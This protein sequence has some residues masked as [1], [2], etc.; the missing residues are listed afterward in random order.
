MTSQM[1]PLLLAARQGLQ[2]AA[3]GSI[4]GRCYKLLQQRWGSQTGACSS[5]TT[6]LYFPQYHHRLQQ[7]LRAASRLFAQGPSTSTST[8]TSSTSG[9]WR[10]YSPM[11]TPHWAR[12]SPPSS[13]LG[14]H[15]PSLPPRPLPTRYTTTRHPSLAHSTRTPSSTRAYSSAPRWQHALQEET[16]RC[17]G[18][19]FGA[20]LRSSGTGLEA[21][22]RQVALHCPDWLSRSSSTATITILNALNLV[23]GQLPKLIGIMLAEFVRCHPLLSGAKADAGFEYYVEVP[24]VGVEVWRWRGVEGLHLRCC[25]A[26]MLLV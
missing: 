12:T 19:S 21:V 11:Q 14:C 17:S 9:I 2:A 22:W 18:T 20:A 8:S 1:Q 24:E 13:R 25:F 7:Q 23:N 10:S 5:H 26:V 16:L 3:E 6:L 4:S 15:A